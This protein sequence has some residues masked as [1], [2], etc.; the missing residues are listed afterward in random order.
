MSLKNYQFISDASIILGILAMIVCI[1]SDIP[2]PY[3]KLTLVTLPMI[4]A[5][6]YYSLMEIEAKRKT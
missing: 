2:E 3:R 4:L 6:N 1:F 5:V